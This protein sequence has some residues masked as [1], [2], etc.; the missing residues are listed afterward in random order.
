MQAG[1]TMENVMPKVFGEV[2]GNTFESLA[3]QSGGLS[4]GSLA[5]KS[6]EAEKPAFT[7]Y[8]ILAYINKCEV[9]IESMPDDETYPEVILV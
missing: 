4:F 3:G 5:Q 7:A 8:V 1:G 6:P 2:T 9:T